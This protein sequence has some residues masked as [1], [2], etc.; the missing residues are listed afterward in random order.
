MP[1]PY[2]PF[3]NLSLVH[4]IYRALAKEPK[5]NTGKI[6]YFL[7]NNTYNTDESQMLYDNKRNQIEKL[8]TI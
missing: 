8:N 3:V 2:I 4:L 5:V 6:F 1:L 7:P